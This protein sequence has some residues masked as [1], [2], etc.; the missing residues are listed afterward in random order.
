MRL[1]QGAD[2][3]LPASF[4]EDMFDRLGVD[5]LVRY[6]GSE[7]MRKGYRLWQQL[8]TDVITFMPVGQNQCLRG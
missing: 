8:N 5:Y 1:S 3:H 4:P 6:D 2:E 7:G